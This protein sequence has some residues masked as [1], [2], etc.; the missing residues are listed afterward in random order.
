MS[1]L[2][3]TSSSPGLPKAFEY[4]IF[5][6]IDNVAGFRD[7]MRSYVIPKISTAREVFGMMKNKTFPPSGFPN[8]HWEYVGCSVGFSSRG[9]AE[10]N[11]TDYLHDE[12]FHRGQKRDAKD[13]GDAG[14]ER[15]GVFQP[16]WD[17]KYLEDIHGVFQITAHNNNK[18]TEFVS[19]LRKAF[20]HSAGIK[21]VLYLSTKFRPDPHTPQEHFGFRDGIAKPEFKGYTFDDELPMK[22]AGSPVVDPGLILMGRKGDLEK[23]RRPS[24]AIDGSFFVFRKLKQLVPEFHAFLQENGAK[25]FP[26]LKP[27][28]A[29]DKLGARIFGRWK[30]GII[31]SIL[32]FIP[33]LIYFFYRNTRSPLTR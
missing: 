9:L 28:A 33:Q 2:S 22:F 14:S 31:Y 4:F 11:L 6:Q 5:F 8:D 29:A 16:D 23:E 26:T 21:Q 25:I 15:N 13:L 17:T 1:L 18:G 3:Y 20:A 19:N 24:W 7:T 27:D 30:S 10:L 32:Q 12:A